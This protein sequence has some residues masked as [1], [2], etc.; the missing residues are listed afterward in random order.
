MRGKGTN[1]V[2]LM[3][4][5]TGAAV[6]AAAFLI[7]FASA[8]DAHE[9]PLSPAQIALFESEHLAGVRQPA[10]L[11][12]GFRHTGADG[13]EP[14]EDRVD[15]DVRPRDDG[16]KDVWTDF[17][18]GERHAPFPPMI[19]FRGNPVV[20]FYLERDVGEMHRRTGG[21]ATY[22]RNRIRGALVDSAEIRP[23]EVSQDGKTLPAR[24]ITL[25]PFTGDAH[26]ARF[27]GLADK[28]YRFVLADGVPGSIYLIGSELPGAPGEPARLAETLTF[29]KQLPCGGAEGPCAQ[30]GV[31]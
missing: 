10:R 28:L 24:E 5:A 26:L 16:A 27:P 11:E 14:F 19:G 2:E 6:L 4:S 1:E 17:L 25:R 8:L 13:G 15:V 9:A 22:F 31:Q 23:T 20:M 3:K 29:A 7:C 12:Y 30:E 21:T 18:S